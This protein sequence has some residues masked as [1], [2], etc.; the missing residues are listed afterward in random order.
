MLLQYQVSLVQTERFPT[1]VGTV[2][3]SLIAVISAVIVAITGPV[4]WDAAATVAFEL[5]AG[6]GMATACFIAVV[7]TVVVCTHTRTHDFSK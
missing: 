7:P 1:L 6:A 3:V 5:D 2:G 4:F